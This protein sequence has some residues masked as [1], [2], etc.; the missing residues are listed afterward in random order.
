M[1]SFNTVTYPPNKIQNSTHRY[2]ITRSIRTIFAHILGGHPERVARI[3]IFFI[4]GSAH[5]NELRY[6]Q[7]VVVSDNCL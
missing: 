5:P 4:L 7:K 6:A 1:S 3:P 2:N